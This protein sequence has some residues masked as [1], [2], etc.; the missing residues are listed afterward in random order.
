MSEVRKINIVSL[1]CW[2]VG[3]YEF[4]MQIISIK[5][6]DIKGCLATSIDGLYD[7]RTHE[8]NYF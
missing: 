7:L 4:N 6:D 2:H 1:S 5:H 8:I 3:R